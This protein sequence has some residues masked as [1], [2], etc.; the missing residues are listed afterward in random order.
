[1]NSI[2]RNILEQ[3]GKEYSWIDK[4]LSTLSDPFDRRKRYK[5]EQ[6]RYFGSWD[7]ALDLSTGGGLWLSDP[8]VARIIKDSLHFYDGQRYR[9]DAY[10]IMPNHVHVVFKPLSDP[11]GSVYSLSTIMHSIKRY[12]AR[13]ANKLLDR[14]GQFWQHESYDHV[15]RDDAELQQIV[16]YVIYNPVSAGLVDHWD[17]WVWTYCRFDLTGG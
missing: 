12:T 10:C 15:I 8:R 14:E 9:L 11:E 16:R 1:V 4:S 6:N 17:D 3:L 13:E 2:P 7:K 5:I